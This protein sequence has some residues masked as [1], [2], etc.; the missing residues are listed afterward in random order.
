MAVA[1][2][3]TTRA[4]QDEPQR[5]VHHNRGDWTDAII[6]LA[7]MAEHRVEVPFSRS[8]GAFGFKTVARLSESCFPGGHDSE[9][10]ATEKYP[11]TCLDPR[12]ATVPPC[13]NS[14]RSF[15]LES[16]LKH[17][18]TD[19]TERGT[20][21]LN[22]L[23]RAAELIDPDAVALVLQT[24]GT[25]A[26]PK[27]V[28][29]THRNLLTNAIAKL[30]AVP[31]TTSDRRLSLLPMS[32]AYART[33]DFGT[34]LIAGGQLAIGKGW[35]GW[36]RFADALKPTLINV[37][38]SIAQRLVDDPSA[39][40][41]RLLGCGGAAMQRGEFDRWTRRGV[42]VIQGYGLTEAGPCVCSS[43]PSEVMAG[44]V[45]RPVPGVRVR[46]RS[47]EL[48]VR[49]PGVMAG[50]DHDPT[51]TEAKLTADGWLRTGDEAWIDDA[52]R[53][54]ILG[55]IDDVIVLANGYK[56]H[57]G[58]I[59]QAIVAGC[60]ASPVVLIHLGGCDVI[61]GYETQSPTMTDEKVTSVAVSRL[62]GGTRVH[63]R[64][65]VPPVGQLPGELTLKG[66]VRRDMVA[67]RFLP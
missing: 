28:M 24:G 66:S 50:Y 60:D 5:L 3:Q 34:W 54:W 38:P 13:F 19:I 43:T 31:Q 8:Q 42:T 62:P 29:L 52:G 63:A 7:C 27:G 17:R 65:L 51:S 61:V 33:C 47:S 9:S 4:I 37:T 18:V 48:Q 22:R 35:E 15:N 10:R 11:A 59:E 55:R 41:L 56:I 25:T 1:V 2:V 16:V 6:A 44:C 39:S 23:Q 26:T 32:H 58:G 12:L 57:P 49:G 46:L 64:R 53:V 21:A 67:R 20:E 30:A 36:R 45:G 40:S 14:E